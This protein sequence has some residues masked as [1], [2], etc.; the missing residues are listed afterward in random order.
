MKKSFQHAQLASAAATLL[1]IVII[2]AMAVLGY[3]FKKS[4]DDLWK[5]L[6]MK[7][8]DANSSIQLSFSREFLAYGGA[9]NL[10]NI[11]TGN[12]KAVAQEL[13]N[14]TKQFMNTQFKASY[15]KQKAAAKPQEPK[16]EAV[17]SW[18]QIQKEE[19]SRLEKSI[20][21][22]EASMKAMNKDMQQVFAGGLEKQKQS[23]EEC[24]KPGNRTITA[25]AQAEKN[26][27]DWKRFAYK[28]DLK[29]WE[30]QHPENFNGLIKKRLQKMLEATANIDF[31]AELITVGNRKIFAKPEYERK[32]REWKMAF[33]AGK[34]VT[35]LTRAYAQQWLSE[36]K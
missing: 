13:L 17:R 5:Q 12:R 8:Q 15:E 26:G 36:V 32:G 23:L 34:E 1:G 35:E 16:L 31:N 3:G 6:G 2:S 30:E 29:N 27:Q 28:Q 9:R 21:E 11:A 4:A 19:I 33:R 10:K 24:K 18:E 25:M 22:T 7:Q 14:Y 20:S